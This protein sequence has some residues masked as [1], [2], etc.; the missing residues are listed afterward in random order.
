MSSL[1]ASLGTTAGLALGKRVLL[2]LLAVGV[3]G[4]GVG[5]GTFAT[6][7]AT[8]TNPS[9]TFTAGTLQMTNSSGCTSA[10]S[11]TNDCTAISFSTP[12]AGI[13]PGSVYTG[14]VTIANTGTLAG[15][16][17]L[18]LNNVASAAGTCGTGSCE[19]LT[20]T[21]GG[22]PLQITILDSKGAAAA[23]QRCIFGQGAGSSAADGA[24]ATLS[25]GGDGDAAYRLTAANT[26]LASGR[27]LLG[28][29]AASQWP[30]AESHT[31]T[32]KVLFPNSAGNTYQGANASFDLVWAA[33]Q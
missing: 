17:T 3:L 26:A 14:S 19:A 25:A 32:I 8:T 29:S 28:D 21:T 27:A 23:G 4:S 16:Y 22:Y 20:S 7:S 9:N 18:T 31:Y 24:C 1:I 33:A 12:A 30:A 15:T 2:S 5:V 11:G 13:S 10:V 6:F